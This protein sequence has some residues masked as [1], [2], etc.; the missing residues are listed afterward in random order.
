MVYSHDAFLS[1]SFIYYAA[2]VL[3]CTGL[4]VII[5]SNNL[6]KKLFGLSMLQSS[7][8]II[9]IAAGNVKNA[10]PPILNGTIPTEAYSNPLPQ[11]LILT[12]IVVSLACLAVGLALAVRIKR[13][14]GKAEED[15]L[16]E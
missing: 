8:M 5:T 11:V 2:T 10:A 7:V 3:F 14:F 16:N 12:A 6:I 15:A 1:G 9:F 13:E 4:Y